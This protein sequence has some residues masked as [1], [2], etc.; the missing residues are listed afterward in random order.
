MGERHMNQNQIDSLHRLEAGGHM[1][2]MVSQETFD[3]A[4]KEN[5]DDFEMEFDEALQEAIGQF[6]LQGVD[7]RNI[8]KDDPASRQNI[9]AGVKAACET[10]REC[11]LAVEAGE[12]NEEGIRTI[13][14][15][16]KAKT[17]TGLADMLTE[18]NISDEP[19]AAAGD[20]GAVGI[21]TAVLTWMT[22]D[23]E[24]VLATFETLTSLF[25]LDQNKEG[26]AGCCNPT[27]GTVIG[28]LSHH[29][30]DA[31]VQE[32]G[33]AAIKQACVKFEWMKN[34]F[35]ES[36]VVDL[37]VTVLKAHGEH[38]K[39]ARAA[40]LVMRQLVLRDDHRE[41]TDQCFD[42][43]RE[44]NEKKALQEA[45]TVLRRHQKDLDIVP[46]VLSCLACCALNKDNVDALVRCEVRDIALDVFRENPDHTGL[47]K[48]ACFLLGS[49]SMLDEQKKLIGQGDGMALI[50]SSMDRHRADTKVL[51][52]ALK[53]VAILTLRMP[54]NATRLAE[55]GS[56]PLIMDLMRAHADKANLQASCLTL[57]RNV[58]ARNQELVPG[59]KDEGVEELVRR[60]SSMPGCNELAF[61]A[62]RDLHC[63]ATFKEEWKG[64]IVYEKRL[65]QGDGSIE[66]PEFIELM[67]QTKEDM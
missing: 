23:K 61:A 46:V 29:I 47:V 48:D 66:D 39:V 41:Q 7:L 15:D 52:K 13:P 9:T 14:N 17:L 24:L 57:I 3:N 65:A 45:C 67:K 55:T 59:L 8:R 64:D 19:R 43:A 12:L 4:V 33:M 60:A 20:E 11:V 26:A 30:N 51:A 1:R 38:P 58:V 28:A 34:T 31:E 10:L 36:N 42:R 50:I 56:M 44:L 5:M 6:T 16:T 27:S 54:E 2:V 35:D 63:D 18:V 32:G 49:I 22:R 25:K 53:A 21:C 40:C 37:L 62:L